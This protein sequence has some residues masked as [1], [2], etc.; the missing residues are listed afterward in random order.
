VALAYASKNSLIA[1]LASAMALPGYTTTS[2]V[3]VLRSVDAM[4]L[5]NRSCQAACALRQ[6]F[7]I[8]SRDPEP[9]NGMRLRRGGKSHEP[10]TAANDS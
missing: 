9:S 4:P 3:N 1:L 7:F 8:S 6:T 2:A 10:P 5:A